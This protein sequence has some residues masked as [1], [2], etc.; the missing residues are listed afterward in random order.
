RDQN[1]G[2]KMLLANYRGLDGLYTNVLEYATS[3][4]GHTDGLEHMREELFGSLKQIVGSIVILFSP[5]SPSSLAKLLS[6]PH[7]RVNNVIDSLRSILEVSQ[8]AVDGES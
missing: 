2:L 1:E 8:A 4:W 6:L 7:N 3:T 5:L